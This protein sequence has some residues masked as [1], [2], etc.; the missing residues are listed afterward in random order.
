MTTTHDSLYFLSIVSLTNR[1]ALCGE[2]EACGQHRAQR[3]REGGWGMR[4]VRA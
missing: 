2:P 3:G 1:A 4:C